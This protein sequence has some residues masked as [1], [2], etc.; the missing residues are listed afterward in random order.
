MSI[1]F[2]AVLLPLAVLTTPA[3]ADLT[4]VDRNTPPCPVLIP[5][6]CSKIERLAGKELARYLSEI[7]GQKFPMRAVKE[8]PAGRAILVGGF[9]RSAAEGLGLDG[10]VLRTDGDRLIICGVHSRGTIYGV[11]GFLEEVLGCRWWSHNEE[12]VPQTDAIRVGELNVRIDP[13]FSLHRLYNRE[14][15]NRRNNF[16]Y[17]SRSTGA[18]YFTGG[19]SLYPLLRGYAKEHPEIYPMNKKGERTANNLH[20]CYLAPGIAEA[21]AEALKR[22]VQKRDGGVTYTIY[23]AGMGD[24][25]GGMCR[26]EK[27]SKV[28]KEETWTD[29]DGRKKPGYTATLLRMMNST[30][31]ILQQKYPGIRVGTFAYMSLEAPPAKTRPADNVVIRVPRLRHCS[32]HPARTCPRNRSY[33]RNLQRWCEITSAGVYIWEYGANFKNFIFPWP[34]VHSIAD[35]IRLY[36]EM[37]VRGVMVQGN[38]VTTG[39]DLV[40]LKNYVW[41]H[42]MWDPTL[43][44]DP[45]IRE[46]CD[47]YYG[48][49]ADAMYAYVQA[50]ENSVREPKTIHA[51]EFA[52]PGYLTQ[53]AREKLRRLRA[54]TITASGGRDP[55][56]RRVLEGTVGIAALTLFNPGPLVE[57]D[58][59][60]VGKNL[61]EYTYDRAREVVSHVR[62]SGFNEWTNGKS[63]WTG[64]LLSHGGP[65]HTLGAGEVKVKV[66][67]LLRGQIR[68]I[69]YRGRSLLVPGTDSDAR[70]HPATGGIVSD[71]GNVLWSVEGKPGGRTIALHD[72]FEIPGWRFRTKAGVRKRIELGPDGRS[73]RVLV[74]KTRGKPAPVSVRTTYGFGGGSVSYRSA[75][76]QWRDLPL[77]GGAAQAGVEKFEALRISFPGR[78]CAVVDTYFSPAD[79][80]ARVSRDRK[81]GILTTL[82][83]TDPIGPSPERESSLA[84]MEM[85]MQMQEP[86]HSPLTR[87]TPPLLRKLE[88]MP[89]NER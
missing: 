77:S 80:V 89:L 8:P 7:S 31:E 33:L 27:C 11:Y 63:N 64:F 22:Q 76:G 40:V 51:G 10:Y 75:D 65:L 46:F 45:L 48:P 59:Q 57:K 43:K 32:V 35:N 85:L 66:A 12:Y 56:Q 55:Y 17:K 24:W 5:Q 61:G 70:W 3:Q 23:F 73:L 16:R 71:I 82:V 69:S 50:V 14:A 30:G 44:T 37:G 9:D 19:H 84:D 72:A 49:A 28:Y 47:G 15:Q 34:S 78:G 41:R 88:I 53:P 36:A 18:E 39:S 13:P 54:K 81:K 25:Y 79:K 74:E 26:C 52:R 68:Q 87:A 58:G 1:R 6:G 86:A 83:A 67:P 21:L 2:S 60:L 38:Y 4:L 20:F 29:P 42:L 62:N